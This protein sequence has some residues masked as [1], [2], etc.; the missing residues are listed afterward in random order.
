MSG[1]MIRQVMRSPPRVGAV[2][3]TGTGIGP[4]AAGRPIAS[5]AGRDTRRSPALGGEEA[6]RVGGPRSGPCSLGE[7]AAAAAP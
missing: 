2:L 1:A 5:N 3:F 6:Q 4:A 7:A